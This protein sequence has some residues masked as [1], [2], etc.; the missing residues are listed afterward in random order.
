MWVRRYR[1]ASAT[2]PSGKPNRGSGA[3]RF[4]DGHHD[5]DVAQ[6]F[7][8]GNLGGLGVE[9]ALRK[10]IHLSGKLVN[11]I[12]AELHAIAAT[13]PDAAKSI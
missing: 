13:T 5:P 12:K 6:T 3:G 2:A 8:A 11:R 7:L 4:V 10:G 1:E 9:D